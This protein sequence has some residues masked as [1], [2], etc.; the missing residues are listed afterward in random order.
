MVFNEVSG[1]KIPRS[2]EVCNDN[3]GLML[4]FSDD[5]E[6]ASD[7][8]FG[9]S[10]STAH[11]V[12]ESMMSG[13][14]Q[15]GIDLRQFLAFAIDLVTILHELHG[16]GVTHCNI[17]PTS[18]G[19][20]VEDKAVLGDLSYST[21]LEREDAHAEVISSRQLPFMS[22][23]SSGR[24][25]RSVDY[26]SDFYSLGITFYYLLTGRCPFVSDNALD[27]IYQ[28]IAHVAVP[29]HEVCED[30]PECISLLVQ[31][32]MEKTAEDRYQTGEGLVSDLQ[33]LLDFSQDERLELYDEFVPGLADTASQFTIPQRLFGRDDDIQTLLSSFGQVKQNG[34]GNMVIIKGSSG[35]GKSSLVNEIHRP[36]LESKS[37]FSSGKFDQ[38]KRGI[39]F[40]S[41][42][43]ACGELIRQLASELDLRLEEWKEE[44]LQTLGGDAAAIFDVLPELSRLYG[45]SFIPPQ[46][47]ELGPT[48][49]EQRFTAAFLRFI[50]V[51]AKRGCPLVLF[52]D[53]IQ[54]SSV[55]E[56]NLIANIVMAASASDACSLSVVVAYRDNEVQEGHHAL[57]MLRTIK[58]AEVPVQV[59]EI[60]SM[61][62]HAV[63]EMIAATLRISPDDNNPELETLTKLILAKTDGNAFFITQ[64]LR[65]FNE[66]QHFYYDFAK[67][68][69]RFNLVAILNEDL[70]ITVVDLLISQIKQLSPRTQHCL[71]IAACIG[72][73]RFSLRTLAVVLEQKL[74]TTSK[75]LWDA[76]QTGLVIPTSSAYKASSYEVVQTR[77]TEMEVDPSSSGASSAA[78]ELPSSEATYRFLHDRVQQASY[79]LVAPEDLPQLHMTIGLRLFRHYKKE[80]L[81][82]QYVFE[83]VNQL[84]RGL[85]LLS[86]E[87]IRLAIELNLQAGKKAL[88]STAFDA[89][90]QYL[91]VAK[92]LAPESWWTDN[93]ELSLDINL[94]YT[95][96]LY[97]VQ[98]YHT[99]V[100][101]LKLTAEKTR[102]PVQRAQIMYRMIDVYMGLDDLPAAIEIGLSAMELLGMQIPRTAEAAAACMRELRPKLDLSTEQIDAIADMS[103]TT[104]PRSVLLQSLATSVCLPIYLSRPELLQAVAASVVLM[105]LTSGVTE[106]GAYPIIMF[107]VTLSHSQPTVRSRMQGYHMG[108]A[109]VKIVNRTSA[110][111]LSATTP[112][113]LKVFASHICFWNKPTRACLVY[114]NSALTTGMQTFNVEYTAYAYTE[115]CSY[116]FWAGEPLPSVVQRMAGHLPIIR[117]FKQ[118]Q[119]IWYCSVQLQSYANFMS[120]SRDPAEIDGQYFSL[121]LE[122]DALLATDSHP[123][124]FVFYMT[125]LLVAVYFHR[126]I[127]VAIDLIKELEKYAPGSQGTCYI[128][129]FAFLVCSSLVRNFTTLQP[130]DLAKFYEYLGNLRF[131]ESGSPSTFNHEVY[132]IEA[133]ILREE[134][135]DLDALEKFETAY[136]MALG[137]GNIHEAGHIAERTY[138]WL[139]TKSTILARKHVFKAY[140]CF[141]VAGFKSKTRDLR[142]RYPDVLTHE[143]L[144]QHIPEELVPFRPVNMQMNRDGTL[145]KVVSSAPQES[146]LPEAKSDAADDRDDNMQ[147]HRSIASKTD[148]TWHT[149]PS[150]KGSVKS[151]R[152]GHM[153]P[154]TLSHPSQVANSE[155]P[156]ESDITPTGTMSSYLSRQKHNVLGR[157]TTTSSGP[158]QESTRTSSMS[159][160]RTLVEGEKDFDLDVALKASVMISDVLQVSEVLKRLIETVLLHAGADYGVLLLVDDGNLYV[161]ATGRNSHVDIVSHQLLSMKSQIVPSAVVNYVSR[162]RETV[163][164][165]SGQDHKSFQA[166]FG[167]DPYLKDKRIRSIM[168]MPIQNSLKLTGVLYLENSSTAYTFGPR[169]VELLNF[170][171]TQAAIAIEKA[172]LYTD[173]EVAKN[174]AQASN[175]MKSEFLSTIS[176]E[177]RTPFNAVLGMSGFL[178]DTQL[179]PMQIDY[180]ETIRNSSKELLRVIDDILDFSKMEHGTFDLHKEDFSLRD[181]IEG[182]M[183]ITAERAAS[184]ELELAYFNNHAEF[185]DILIN[186]ITRFRQVVINLLGNSIKFTE[187]GSVV[188]TSN[189]TLLKSAAGNSPAVYRIQVSVQD[190]GIG[191][192]EEDHKKLFKLFTQIDS[193]LARS[194]SGTGLGLAISEKL[195]RL[196]GG[197]IWVESKAGEGS[198][199]HFTVVSEVR[200]SAPPMPHPFSP[201]LQGL[202][203]LILDDSDV[204]T[205]ALS[206]TLEWLGMRVLIS[207][208][209]NELLHAISTN[210][211]GSF[212]IALIDLHY[213]LAEEVLPQLA[214]YDPACTIIRLSRFGFRQKFD[215]KYQYLIK[216]V[217]RE[218]LARVVAEAI[219][220]ELVKENKCVKPKDDTKINP[221]NM[222]LNHP[223]RILLAEDN[224]INS[225]VALQHLKR[226]GYTAT[227]AKDGQYCLE[228]EE[229]AIYDVILMDVQMPRLD[230]CQ[231]ASKLRAK[232]ARE[233]SRSPRVIAMTANAMKGDMERCLAAGMHAYCQK[234]I[235]VDVLAQRLLEATRRPE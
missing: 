172:R 101:N 89:S 223:L 133:E 93:L 100:E 171:C 111:S 84:N 166:K 73:N 165:G 83:I 102:G 28:H 62:L 113:V 218:R 215:E 56:M 230:G 157:T 162:L 145:S 44:I 9:R 29:L 90:M 202:G 151:L 104:D 14:R 188:L 220:P 75:D 200:T 34:G 97:A 168:C 76:L 224:M 170:L 190:T 49:R 189:A 191:I 115:S 103:I 138:L 114:F 78:E 130:A 66:Q 39:P 27:L 26:R 167:K 69:W 92:R 161:E 81:V 1:I 129:K 195:V 158:S 203:V 221:I 146:R 7:V 208:T 53:D 16:R 147:D 159:N 61:S 20:D 11:P 91:G 94:S 45:D 108:L 24:I 60:T 3:K 154:R 211:A 17:N 136:A 207:K 72:T 18:I 185:P 95:D 50:L 63:R 137:V 212:R 54:W 177:I 57:S 38:Y 125:K 143:A 74:R 227:H 139:D 82:E 52:L 175:K 70:P 32:L 99:A 126:P 149:G 109:A 150:L 33:S 122:F 142:T 193:S 35:V 59:I 118:M 173:L 204:A 135:R 141:K 80:N 116:S 131:Y 187:K 148:R 43:Q 55:A 235:I 37:F 87:E 67:R 6:I 117:R 121:N 123:Q 2:I 228:E 5:G 106:A 42:L 22:P 181:C 15:T 4:V 127:E 160:K 85:E 12:E 10:T 153:P 132:F 214:R 71:Q 152:L 25:N 58:E 196:M 156:I 231:T 112:K 110:I 217:K 232:Y 206:E 226:M 40:F 180:V 198:V 124:I 140:D 233:P 13:A 19:V 120:E 48:E 65:R 174:E 229:K 183:Q 134:G 182:A 23:E 176:H 30:L 144:E 164:L 21:F 51:F 98:N 96:A 219:Y 186:D 128:A 179:S 41:L 178:L 197:Q 36:V 47:S 210:P 64:L 184:K 105:S 225:R 107:G 192:K 155:S 31:K 222:A 163:V 213:G 216:P 119:S 169:R 205:R 88:Q 209:V 86:E 68:T 8:Y 201:K 77:E 46:M 79:Q 234:P 194:F 199:F